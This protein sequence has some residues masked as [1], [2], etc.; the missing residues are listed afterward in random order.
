MLRL[1][2]VLRFIVC[3]SGNKRAVDEGS[4]HGGTGRRD[5]HLHGVV[6][7][8]RRGSEAAVV[9]L[10][11]ELNPRLLRFLRARAG[12]AGDDL[13]G[14][15]W[16]A[17]AARIDQF[18]GDWDDFRSW[19]FAIARHRVAD[20][21]RSD[22]RR[23]AILE[24]S[25]FDPSSAACGDGSDEPALEH[26]SGE[27]AASL[28]ATVLNADQAEVV[29]LRVFGDLDADQVGAIM[30]RSPGWVRVTQHRALRRLAT[31]FSDRELTVPS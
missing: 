31:H 28:I 4:D 12:Q 6:D 3:G 13:G 29:L 24:A 20:H 27:Q 30:H 14:E 5:R 15:V 23:R 9:E 16:L 22:H 25:G 18:E 21:H 7:A 17:V 8:A 11:A 2:A 26:L 10:F 1:F 19:F